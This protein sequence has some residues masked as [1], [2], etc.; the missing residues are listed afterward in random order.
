MNPYKNTTFAQRA[1]LCVTALAA[2]LMVGVSQVN[3]ET[4][5]AKASVAIAAPAAT[6]PVIRKLENGYIAATRRVTWTK[7]TFTLTDKRI[8]NIKQY[9]TA[10]QK[11]GKNVDVLLKALDAY[12]PAINTDKEVFVEATTWLEKHPGFDE[13]GKVTD[14]KEAQA[15]LDNI[16]AVLKKSDEI[17]YAAEKAMST[18]MREYR[19][20]QK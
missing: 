13:K 14:A 16:N 11:A 19:Q 6:S 3:A 15:T 2:S 8:D 17:R 1:T 5:L 12:V 7:Q 10:Q 4:G 9:I 20:S 18:A